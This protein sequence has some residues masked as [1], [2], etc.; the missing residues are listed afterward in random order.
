LPR[1]PEALYVDEV[2]RQRV[3]RSPF[4][5][6]NYSSR[7]HAR[8]RLELDRR[9]RSL[10][11]TVRLYSTASADVKS[12]WSDAI[13]ARWSHARE[14]VVAGGRPRRYPIV[15]GIEWSGDAPSADHRVEPSDPALRRNGTCGLGGTVHMN[16]WG[17]RDTV[18]VVH[19]FGHMLGNTDEYFTTNGVD[20]T[21]RGRKRGYRDVGG[22][23]MNNSVE[24]P[25]DRHFEL[26]RRKAAELLGVSAPRCAVC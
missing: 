17:T 1:A 9:A 18:D 19:E 26:I 14:L 13:V 12:A 25:F 8:F 10:V 5:E 2:I 11:A 7:W 3:E 16:L 20:F 21:E 24:E 22:G 23:I 15:I 6:W 4:P